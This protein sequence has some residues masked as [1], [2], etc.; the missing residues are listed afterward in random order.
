MKKINLP[1]GILLF[2][3]ILLLGITLLD[4][5]YEMDRFGFYIMS[6][7]LS[8]VAF[9][10]INGLFDLSNVKLSY[11]VSGLFGILELSGAII[12]FYRIDYTYFNKELFSKSGSVSFFLYLLKVD[13]WIFDY[14]Y[15]YLC[16]SV[17]LL[18]VFIIW[19]KL[20]KK[21]KSESLSFFS[22]L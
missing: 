11:F 13:Y 15:L 12:Q 6:M 5:Q 7:F 10:V 9:C 1:F 4:E 16:V 17:I 21:Y 14:Q 3:L 19:R 22:I 20:L 2:K 18:F 8:L